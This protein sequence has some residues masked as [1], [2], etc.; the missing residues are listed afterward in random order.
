MLAGRRPEKLVEPARLRV[1]VSLRSRSPVV[2]VRTT[3]N[4]DAVAAAARLLVAAGHDTVAADP[5][6]PTVAGLRGTIAT[7]FAAALPRV[8]A[9]GIDPAALQP[10]TRRHVALGD[11]ALRAGYVREADRDGVAGAARSRSSPTAASTCCSRPALAGAPPAGRRL[12][13]AGRGGPA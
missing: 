3:P 10:R 4:R 12:V 2:G 8:E 5:V 6:Y 11:W 7:W 9:A 13:T 1:G